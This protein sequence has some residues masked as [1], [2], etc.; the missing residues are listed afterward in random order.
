MDEFSKNEKYIDSIKIFG[1]IHLK[2]PVCLYRYVSRPIQYLLLRHGYLDLLDVKNAS[3]CIDQ[4]VTK[5]NIL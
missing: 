1:R 3:C 4:Q 2:L 5:H